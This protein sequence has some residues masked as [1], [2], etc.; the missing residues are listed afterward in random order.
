MAKKSLPPPPQP[1]ALE[2]HSIYILSAVV[3]LLVIVLFFYLRKRK[4]AAD[5]RKSMASGPKAIIVVSDGVFEV[6]SVATAY[7]AFSERG[8]RVVLASQSGEPTRPEQRSLESP[9]SKAAAENQDPA[10]LAVFAKCGDKGPAALKTM[11]PA[12][13]AIVYVSGGARMLFDLRQSDLSGPSP[14]A[15]CAALRRLSE[16]VHRRGGV[17]GGVGHG[18]HGVPEIE[19]GSVRRVVGRLDSAAEEVAKEMLQRWDEAQR[20]D[21]PPPLTTR[22]TQRHSLRSSPAQPGSPRSPPAA[23]PAKKAE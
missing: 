19:G 3:T 18:L 15:Y 11:R 14:T 16:E 5:R 20:G 12:N 13:T 1:L 8:L 23:S 6:N 22:P 10:W 9:M 21:A 17:I 7:K 4:K 2:K